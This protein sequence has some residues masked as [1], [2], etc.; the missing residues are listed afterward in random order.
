MPASC[1]SE[2]FHFMQVGRYFQKKMCWVLANTPKVI[3]KNIISILSFCIYKM[4]HFQ[5][6]KSNFGYNFLI[7]DLHQS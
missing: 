1:S 4:Q 2:M 7:Q 3:I 5:V 6:V